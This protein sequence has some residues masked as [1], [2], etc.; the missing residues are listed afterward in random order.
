MS[1]PAMR[2]LSFRA[3]LLSI[4]LAMILA[5]ANTYLGLFAGLTIATA[6]PAAVVS[7]AVLRVLG[8]GTILENNIVQTGASAGSSIA[9]GVIFTIPA[10]LI[11]GYWQDFK[12]SWVLAIAGLGGLLGVLFSVPLRRTM[13][14]ED[15]LPFPEGKAAAEVLKAGDNPGPGLKI[16]GFSAAIG[17]FV[18]LAAESGLRMIPDN[19]AVAGFMGKYLGYM[20]TNLSPALLGVGYIVGLNI[21]IVVLSGAVL[22]YNIAIPL[23]HWLAPSF[24]PAMAARLAGLSAADAAGVIRGDKIRFLGVGAMLVG[25]IWTLFSLRKSLLSGVRSGIAAARKGSDANVSETERDLPMKWMLVSLVLFVIPLLLLYQAIVGRW[26]VSVPMAVIMVVAGFL[27][28][29]VSAY[30]AGLVGSSNNPVSG[31]TIATILFASVVLMLLLGADSPIGAV[32]AIMI[33]AVVCCAAA[34]GGDNLQDLKAGY[35]V[36]ATPWKQQL[37]LGIGALS[38]ALVMAPVLNLLAQAYGIGPATAEHPNSLNA[39]QATLM[40]SVA[41]GMFGGELPWDMIALGGV[42][43]AAI[44][45]FDGWLK[46]RGSSFRVPV[47]AAAIG[48]YLPLELMVPIFLGGLLAHLVERRA[49]VAAHDEAARDR[50]HRPGTLFAAGL[51]TGEALMGIAIAVP[52]V[53]SERA[54]VLALPA[55]LHFGQGVGLAVLALVG[56]L[57]LRSAGRGAARGV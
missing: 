44:I 57:L 39:P 16:L 34:V 12:Y 13:I 29:S 56:W 45:A 9:A 10:L 50:V 49:G 53:I 11:L 17:G 30:L 27:F 41:K 25:G 5:A 1:V 55:D 37:M 26:T 19:A 36:G 31:I 24:D 15:P 18:K 52:I 21:G 51:I 4:V 2:Q 28:V 20:G 35:I 48:I 22:S 43:G 40:A 38:C 7:M 14:V 8:G 23:Y 33:G 42:V 47:L 46:A 3:V 32:A 6:I 54:D